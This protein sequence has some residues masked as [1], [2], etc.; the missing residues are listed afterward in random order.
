MKKFPSIEQFRNVIKE[1]VLC[2]DFKG[3]DGNNS[4][5]YRHDLMM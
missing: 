5:I 3:K 2:H 4:L 1:V